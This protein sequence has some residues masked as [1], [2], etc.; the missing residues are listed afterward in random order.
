MI[1]SGASISVG[2]KVGLRKIT[3]SFIIYFLVS[4]VDNFSCTDPKEGLGFWV[5]WKIIKL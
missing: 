3:V 4:A 2:K 1:M 5:P